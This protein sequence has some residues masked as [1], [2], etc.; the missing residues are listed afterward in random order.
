MS[1]P[2]VPQ[3]LVPGFLLGGTPVL[4]WGIPVPGRGYPHT[5]QEGIPGW[6][7]SQ[8]HQD[9]VPPTKTG[10]PSPKTR[11]WWG[12]PQP[13]QDGYPQSGQ[14]GLPLARTGVPP[15]ARS[16]WGTLPPQGQFMLGQ[17]MLWVVRLLR[18]PA[19]LSDFVLLGWT[20]AIQFQLLELRI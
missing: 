2:G 10:V 17:V 1:Y 13:G 4:V 12:T 16:G 11:S 9:G 15:P 19:G 6:G 5:R 7:T 14:D 8:S 3:W 18:F 20:S